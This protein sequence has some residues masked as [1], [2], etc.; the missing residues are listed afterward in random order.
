MQNELEILQKTVPPS[1]DLKS[2]KKMVQ[3]SPQRNHSKNR[4]FKSPTFW[5]SNPINHDD[6]Y[7]PKRWE[8]SSSPANRSLDK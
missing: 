6:T 4:D 5:G 3:M 1:R 2:V 7:S 8:Y